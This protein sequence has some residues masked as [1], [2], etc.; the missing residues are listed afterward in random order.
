MKKT[1]LLGCVLIVLS[2]C[3]RNPH[4]DLLRTVQ[5]LEESGDFRGAAIALHSEL[6]DSELTLSQDQRKEL[7]FE[8]DRLDRIREDYSLTRPELLK[9]LE[10]SI[11][12]VTSEELQR[13]ID[14]GKLDR[15]M[16]DGEEFFVSV[17][18]SNL[19]WRY[20]DI[21]ARRQTPPDRTEYE[22]AVWTNCR[23]IKQAALAEGTPYVLPKRFRMVMTVTADAGA[24]PAGTTVRA[25]LPVPRVFPHQ[26]DFQ[27]IES[28]PEVKSIADGL[29]P[30]RSAFLEQDAKP[31]EPVRF[32]VSYEYTT[33]GVFFDLDPDKVAPLTGDDAD[34]RPFL[35]EG[36]H[37]VFTEKIKELSD[38]LTGGESN[39]LK[40]ARTFYN[41][42]AENIQYSY[43]L[44]Y[45]TIRNISDYCLTKMYGDCGQEALL[46]IALC[47]YNGIPARWQSGWYTFP[48][49]KTIHDWTE[50]YLEPYGWIPVDPYMGI[51]AM[52]Y[53]SSLDEQKKLEV[54]DF[55]FGGLDQYRMAA[56]SDHSQTLS[57]P[58]KTLRSDTVDFQRGELEADGSN[59]Y[60]DKYSYRLKVTE[61]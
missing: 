48:G 61:M 12:G 53:L 42:I 39:P 44:E 21:R 25:W 33:Y 56:N 6:D 43:A 29:S 3:G 31:D 41:W 37:V 45:S 35:T 23:D 22:T 52:Q 19:F 58:K 55:F 18:R 1:V 14:E 32:Q 47:R 20:P 34:L 46:F 36:P 13:W 4:A 57:P 59:I 24:A 30:I 26:K 28:T 27:L 49:G 8:L 54:R 17:S 9:Q 2:A 5:L 51:F 38:R 16:I 40:V 11:Q 10:A 15:R 7:E 50:I 60:F